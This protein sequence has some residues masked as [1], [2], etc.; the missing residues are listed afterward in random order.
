MQILVLNAGSSSLKWKLLDMPAGTELAGG[1]AERIGEGEAGRM[2]WP[3]GSYEGPIPDHAKALELLK[4]FFDRHPYFKVEAAGHRVVHG[5]TRLIRPV[6]INEEVKSV[7]RSLFDLAPLHN[8]A[9]LA[10]IEAAERI[11]P[12][13][14]QVAVFDTAFHRTIPPREHRY[15]IPSR[16]YE[17]GIRQYGFHGINHQWIA[18]RMAETA[19][20]ARKIISLHLGN[21]ASATAILDGRSVAHSMGFGPLP[22]LIMGTR[23]GDI[24]PSVLLYWMQHDGLDVSEAARILNKESGLKGLTGTNDMR[25]IEERYRQGDASAR[26]AVEMYAYRIKKYIGAYAAVLNGVDALVFT[27]GVGEHS[28]LVR[29]LACSETEY[30]GIRLDKERN[31]NLKGEGDIHADD[32]AVRIRVI[33]AGEEREIA[34][35]TYELVHEHV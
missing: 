32:S 33:P 12:G 19:P 29:E 16:F 5:G 1:A 28:A 17:A 4:A 30:L 10:G 20:Q 15:A 31:R 11:F 27:G 3:G 24:D 13:I 25:E 8:P 14:P 22:G 2:T 34:R 18:R 21:G 23:P 6:L 35:Q 9:N 26:L 7:I